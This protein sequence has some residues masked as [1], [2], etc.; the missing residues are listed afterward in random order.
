MAA[1]KPRSIVLGVALAFCGVAAIVLLCRSADIG[2]G[3]IASL[4]VAADKPACGT[5][6]L[7]I[8]VNAFLSSAKWR[9]TDA[10][11]RQSTDVVPSAVDCLMLTLLGSAIGQVLPV[12]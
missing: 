10:A 11:M 5:L 1:L 4:W 8:T 3:E 7:L 9:L 6:L 12:Q 2:L